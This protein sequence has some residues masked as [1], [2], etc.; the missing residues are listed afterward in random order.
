[1]QTSFKFSLEKFISEQSL[2]IYHKQNLTLT[3]QANYID[4]APEKKQHLGN[5]GKDS[6]NKPFTIQ[7]VLKA[8]RSETK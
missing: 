7:L 6:L 8:K 4:V 5:K 3:A 1:M 2:K